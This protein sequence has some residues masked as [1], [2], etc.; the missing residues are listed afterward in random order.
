QLENIPFSDRGSR[1]LVY[2]D[3]RMPYALYVKLA[4]RLTA[5]TPGLSA[6][7]NRPPFIHSLRLVDGEGRTLPFELTSYPHPLLFQTPLGEFIM[8]FQDRRTLCFGLPPGIPCGISFSIVPDLSRPDERGGEFKSVRNCA[9]STN[10]AVVLNRVE[11][12]GGG[13]DATLAVS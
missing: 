5:L 7:R 9:Y 12:N 11:H 3:R 4:E 1:L 2:R 6:Y 10:G 13:Y 8:A